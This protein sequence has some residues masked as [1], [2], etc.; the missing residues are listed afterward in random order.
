M[1]KILTLAIASASLAFASTSF[2]PAAAAGDDPIY[3]EIAGVSGEVTEKSHK[4]WIEIDSLAW[5]SRGTPAQHTK[6]HDLTI[7]KH[8]DKSSPKLAQAVSTGR[9]FYEIRIDNVD[10]AGHVS[11]DIT[12][13]NVTLT[14][15]KMSSKGDT[16]SESFKLSYATESEK[17]PAAPATVATAPPKV[18]APVKP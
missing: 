4:G 7:T 16:T 2:Q 10:A 6:S 14:S 8:I 11:L 15:V 17:I 5:G 9:Q 12:L 13:H 3:M 1:G 18:T